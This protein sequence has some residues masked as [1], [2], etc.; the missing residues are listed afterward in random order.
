MGLET[1]HWDV[2][3]HLDSDALI[4]AYFKMVF[5]DGDVALIAAALNDMAWAKGVCEI[6]LPENVLLGSIIQAMKALGLE[7]TAKAA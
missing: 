1:A 7:L 5:E 3:D 6:S 4:V 2:V